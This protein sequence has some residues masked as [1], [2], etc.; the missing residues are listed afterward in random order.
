MAMKLMKKVS[1]ILLTA[2]VAASSMQMSVSAKELD[3]GKNY[4]VMIINFDPVFDVDGQEVKMHDLM[5]AWNDPYELADRFA[6]AMSDVSYGNV[7][8]TVAEKIELNEFPVNLEGKAYTTDEYYK[9]FVD[10]CNATDGSYWNY[11]GWED[12]GFSF[13]YDRYFTRFDVYDKV[14][15]GEIDEVWFFGGPMTGVTLFETMMVGK[16]AFWVNGT[17][18]VKEDCRNFIAYGFNYERGLGEMLEDAGHRTESIMSNIYGSPDYAKNYSEYN[19]WERFTA[20]DLVSKGNAGVGNVHFAPNSQSDYDWGNT[21]YV[22]SYCE[23]WLNYPNIS[24]ASKA[25]NCSDWGNGNMEEHHR[26]WFKHL[27]HVEGL[28]EETGIYNN[29]WKYF[30]LEYLNNTAEEVHD[31]TKCVFESIPDVTYTGSAIEPAVTIKDGDTLLTLNEDYTVNYENNIEVGTA[32]AVIQGINGYVGNYVINFEIVPAEEPEIEEPTPSQDV[33]TS[34][35]MMLI[36]LLFS[37]I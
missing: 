11:D 2:S 31:I 7:N 27:P 32:S 12:S 20:Y 34:L 24:G 37:L 15:S 30:S 21:N 28:N 33:L 5:E 9:T 22:Q 36:R 26:W 25:V 14:N 1:T 10:A 8:Y 19:D 16:D 17:P 18:M 23:N 6:D 29:W 3:E 4:K 35:F 13:D